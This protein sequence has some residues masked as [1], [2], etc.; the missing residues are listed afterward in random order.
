MKQL[1][2]LPRLHKLNQP[3]SK[4]RWLIIG[5]I[6]LLVVALIAAYIILSQRYW[7]GYQA[8]ASAR[9]DTIKGA[10]DAALKMTGGSEAEREKKLAAFESVGATLGDTTICDVPMMYQWQGL[11]DQPKSLTQ[12]CR[13]Q[14]EKL[15]AFQSQLHVMTTH[16]RGEVELAKLLA[17]LPSADEV[18]DVK[19]GEIHK[20]WQSAM[21]AVAAAKVPESLTPVKQ[22][23]QQKLEAVTKSWQALLEAHEAKD[24]AKYEAALA[25][26]TTAYGA[27]GEISTLS[28]AS[29]AGLTKQLS[30]SYN[31]AFITKLSS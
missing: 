14:Q 23:A 9:V 25:E 22:L 10:V 31:S 28:E 26:L 16:L 11:L 4:R 12:A 8:D 19:W 18:D 27:L 30:A 21:A 13:L 7:G 29:L 1:K 15:A 20:Q 6:G 17:T 2:T 3:S 5:G 24:R